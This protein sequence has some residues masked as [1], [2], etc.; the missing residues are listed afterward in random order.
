MLDSC[1]FQNFNEIMKINENL[2]LI[3]NNVVLVPYKKHHVEKY[4]EWMQSEE[5]LEKTASEPLTLDEEFEMQHKWWLDEDKCTFIVMNKSDSAIKGEISA[6][7]GDVNL[8]FNDP[9][10]KT[11]AELEV[12]IAEKCMRNRGLG[13]ESVKIMLW[14]AFNKLGVADFIVKIGV[15]NI[16][17]IGLFSKL[18]FKERSRS[19]VFQEIT[20][21]LP[22]HT[23]EFQKNMKLMEQTIR[24]CSYDKQ[25]FKNVNLFDS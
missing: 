5:L 11:E 24:A 15:S 22:C 12:M 14:Y 3:G 2:C 7:A 25:D 19:E 13:K 16:E 17:S 1:S 4:H 18:G 6:M 8:F 21:H 20:F 9:E 23:E 10:N